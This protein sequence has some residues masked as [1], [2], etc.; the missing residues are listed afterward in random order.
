MKG[1]RG[2]WTAALRRGAEPRE[3][4]GRMMKTDSD[5][6]ERNE[7]LAKDLRAKL[8]VL[9]RGQFGQRRNSVRAGGGQKGQ[10]RC[11]EKHVLQI[12]LAEQKKQEGNSNI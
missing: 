12:C 2:G 10:P 7:M 9:R 8:R 1:G 5:G 4:R 6:E 3:V 11:R